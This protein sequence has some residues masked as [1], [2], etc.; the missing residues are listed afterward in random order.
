MTV[1]S[2]M[3]PVF[4]L[5][6]RLRRLRGTPLDPFGYTQERRRERALRDRYLHFAVSLA[7]GLRADNKD[8]ALALAQ[9]PD[10]VRGYGH[11]KLAAL[12]RLDSQWNALIA[13][14]DPGAQSHAVARELKR[15]AN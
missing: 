3:L 5:L 11:V 2:A 13:R 12:D 7:T 15:Q 6:A 1:G 8:A 9:L 4:G 10:Q 14:L